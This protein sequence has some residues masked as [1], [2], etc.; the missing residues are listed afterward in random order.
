M[1]YLLIKRTFFLLC[2]YIVCDSQ[3]YGQVGSFQMH[4]RVYD[5]SQKTLSGVKF[6][7]FE[8][9]KSI[10]TL[11][12]HQNGVFIIHLE[13][14]KSFMLEISKPG[15]VTKRIAINT[16]IPNGKVSTFFDEATLFVLYT[17]SEADLQTKSGLPT[18]KYV[19]DSIQNK[20]VAEELGKK[21]ILVESN[22]CCEQIS[23]LKVDLNNF[24][25]LYLEQELLVKNA[26]KIILEAKKIKNQAN[27]YADS[28]MQDAN[29]RV[30]SIPRII[31][32]DSLNVVSYL[33]KNTKDISPDDYKKYSVDENKFLSKKEVRELRQKIM[34]QSKQSKLT[35][36][37]SLAL[38]G[39]RLKMRQELFEMAKYQLE[40][41]R[42]NA[43]TKE[44]SIKI[45]V[46]ESQLLMM[47]QDIDLAEKELENAQNTLKLKDLE[48]K[49]K[50]IMLVSFLIGSIL[51][52]V[53][54]TIIY[55][56]Y[57]DKKRINRI[58]EYQNQEL[59]KLSI[60][61]SET[62]NGVIITDNSGNYS[63]IN[64]GYTRLFGYEIEEVTGENP[65]NIIVPS[66]ADAINKLL[67]RAI[68]VGEPVSY[69]FEANRKD[70]D[71]IWVQTTVTPILN[72]HGQVSKLIAI[73]SD[74]SELKRAE[75]EILQQ[76]KKLKWQNEQIMDS[77][78]YAKRIQDAILPSEDLIR[79]Y[80]PESFIYFKPR[81]IVSGDFYWF[82]VHDNKLLIA[83][84]DCTGHGVPG[85]F[86][87]L[88]G[89]SLLNHIVNE[90]KIHHPAQ[91]LTELNNGVNLAL[92]QK[93]PGDEERE[94]GMD[95]TVCCFDKN[96]RELQIA[97]ANHTAIIITD[98]E[99]QEFHGDEI[100]IG[101]AYSKISDL[102]FTNHSFPFKEN[103][104]MYLFSDGYQDQIGGPKNKKF[105]VGNFIQFL[106]QNQAEAM[107]LQFDMLNKKFQEWK[108]ENKQT[109]DVLVMGIRLKMNI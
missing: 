7:V 47:K 106:T 77:I 86:M 100:S 71:K 70:G 19:F 26:D 108:G 42:L 69:E 36:K 66:N 9:D 29:R 28:V 83:I 12:T 79:N 58:L 84:V 55:V 1:M 3:I 17:E 50:N 73:D 23:K 76:S 41:D 8:G 32:K 4:G 49:N 30:A 57:R 105:M 14:N 104:M 90:K 65:K 38:K 60:V 82:S 98:G 68:S 72:K 53:L 46:R 15:F 24:K 99:I 93:K 81:D 74:I 48:I 89:N 59:E 61:A 102:Q 91:I 94:D 44:D 22:E 20:F 5:K 37:D 35:V 67:E 13:L 97:C 64:K 63:W 6:E 85:A 62:S 18:V 52:L 95:I 40:L 39:D 92:S 45:E 75:Y 34:H 101:E 88:I 25:T 109:D 87:S 96:H 31:K 11:S 54:L 27:H 2:L 56:S 78:N 51:L 10:D 103:S 21:P 43:R 16:K 80:F 107:N 33:D